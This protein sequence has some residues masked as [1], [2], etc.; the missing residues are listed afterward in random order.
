[1]NLDTV[2]P[3]AAW[4]WRKDMDLMALLEKMECQAM[5][6]LLNAPHLRPIPVGQQSD[7]MWCSIHGDLADRARE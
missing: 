2:H 6:L 1:M 5:Q 4:N 7:L 3:L